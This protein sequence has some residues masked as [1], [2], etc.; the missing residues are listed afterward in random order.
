MNDQEL[1]DAIFHCEQFLSLAKKLKSE[2]PPTHSGSTL[3]GAVKR[4]AT[5]ARYFLANLTRR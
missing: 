5:S 2:N 1:D 4:Q 3:R